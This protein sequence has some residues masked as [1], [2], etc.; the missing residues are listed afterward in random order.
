MRVAT[1]LAVLAVAAFALVILA[2]PNDAPGRWEGE[3][4][5]QHYEVVAART[6]LVRRGEHLE[7]IF[8]RACG[9]CGNERT[10]YLAGLAG[11][12]PCDQS[13]GPSFEYGCR[14][15]RDAWSYAP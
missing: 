4:L 10:G 13:R 2:H 7:E 11:V 9:R 5:H 12:V 8:E 14:M 3:T 1:L 6:E 15:G